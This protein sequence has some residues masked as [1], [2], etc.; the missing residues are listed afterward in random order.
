MLGG[1][2][3]FASFVP[4]AALGCAARQLAT[5]QP[6]AR[7]FHC[8]LSQLSRRCLG[9]AS[10][11]VF[12]GRAIWSC[13]QHVHP[14]RGTLAVIPLSEMSLN[15]IFDSCFDDRGLSFVSP[16]LQ[17]PSTY[18]LRSN[19]AYLEASCKP[20]GLRSELRCSKTQ[21]IRSRFDAGSHPDKVQWTCE[22]LLV[23]CDLECSSVKIER[24][25]RRIAAH[26]GA[27]T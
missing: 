14:R 15:P 27:T 22:D 12:K 19:L 10:L 24:K 1:P 2:P 16:A 25:R 7:M 9:P 13:H 4:P 3:R 23:S 17:A 18:T 26:H 20:F 6:A 21:A 11:D 5:C 8:T